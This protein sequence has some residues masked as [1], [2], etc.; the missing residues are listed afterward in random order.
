[1]GILSRFGDIISANIN[2]L[3]DKAEDP[4]KMIGQY[5]R[6]A[7]DDLTEVKVET[8]AVIAEETLCGRLLNDCRDEIAK[9]QLPTT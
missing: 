3:L 5:L 9:C 4:A 1:M 6:K 2:D 8:A 7:K